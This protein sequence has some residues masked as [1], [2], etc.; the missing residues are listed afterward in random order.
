MDMQMPVMDGHQATLAIRRQP[1][2]ATLPIV[3]MTAHAMA[4]ERERCLAEGMNDHITKPIDPDTLYQAVARWGNPPEGVPDSPAS[5][6]LLASGENLLPAQI[7][8]IDLAD[9][10]RRVANKPLI[11][12]KLLRMFVSDQAH[13]AQMVRRALAEG[14]RPLALR[15]VHTV[16]GVAGNLGAR[17][18]SATA[19][20]LEQL[21]RTDAPAEPV[22]AALAD[23][24]TRLAEQI[25]AIRTALDLAHQPSA[26]PGSDEQP[27]DAGQLAA[28]EPRLTVLRQQVLESDTEAGQTL[29]TLAPALRAAVPAAQVE[30]LEEALEDYDFDRALALLERWLEAD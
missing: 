30:A 8:G 4:E 20:A 22:E 16:H 29:L 11:Y 9:G 17:A 3:A 24:A 14:D 21:L 18:L 15:T 25:A 5:T 19:K 13:A 10:L 28:L 2:F 23:F 12:L 27:V 6:A 1:R 7:P 26:A